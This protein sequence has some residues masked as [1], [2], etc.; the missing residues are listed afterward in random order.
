MTNN[1]LPALR[2]RE[3]FVGAGQYG[4]A[5]RIHR[6]PAQRAEAVGLHVPNRLLVG[7]P[8]SVRA[9]RWAG[10][11][12]EFVGDL[13]VLIPDEQMRIAPVVHADG[14]PILRVTFDDG[15]GRNGSVLEVAFVRVGI[16]YH[17]NLG[18]GVAMNHVVG[19]SI[20]GIARQLVVLSEVRLKSPVAIAA[21]YDAHDVSRI[22]GAR[23]S[24]IFWVP[25]IARA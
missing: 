19:N 9:L 1:P 22:G 6:G 7:M 8:L 23:S 20:Q 10:G 15:V 13:V 11:P 4:Q 3:R 24:R 5:G 18:R 21:I 17:L 14:W 25:G 16:D 2:R 12:T